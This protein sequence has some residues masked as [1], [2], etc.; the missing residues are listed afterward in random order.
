MHEKCKYT[1]TGTLQHFSIL[2]KLIF[3]IN[4]PSN[5]RVTV[6]FSL[7]WKLLYP[8][9]IHKICISMYSLCIVIGKKSKQDPYCSRVLK[10]YNLEVNHP[11]GTLQF[12]AFGLR[13]Q[14]LFWGKYGNCRVGCRKRKWVPGNHSWGSQPGSAFQLSSVKVWGGKESQQQIFNLIPLNYEPR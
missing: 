4:I 7:R 5:T 14:V 13:L 6:R 2:G 1:R 12:W 3:L 11:V 9:F 10:I 8:L